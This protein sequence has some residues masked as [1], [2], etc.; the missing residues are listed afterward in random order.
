M[1]LAHSVSRASTYIEDTSRRR[2]PTPCPDQHAVGT[3]LHGTTAVVYMKLLECKSSAAHI[4]LLNPARHYLFEKAV[5]TCTEEREIISHGILRVELSERC[6]D[7]LRSLPIILAAAQKPQR[8]PHI[9]RMDI[10]RKV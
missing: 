5:D 8:T 7:L 3:H 6:R 9:S 10:Q 1:L 2:Q 4:S